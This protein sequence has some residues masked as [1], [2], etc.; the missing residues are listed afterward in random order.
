[1]P[2][3]TSKPINKNTMKTLS[4]IKSLYFWLNEIESEKNYSFTFYIG[5][6]CFDESNKK[7]IIREIISRN[8]SK[9]NFTE[10]ELGNFALDSECSNISGIIWHSQE[11]VPEC[12]VYDEINE[13]YIHEDDA[14]YGYIRRYEGYFRDN[15]K[16]YQHNGMY[17]HENSLGYHHLEV[18]GDGDILESKYAVYCE[19]VDEYYHIDY[20][21][22][23]ELTGCH[24]RH[25]ENLPKLDSDS[26]ICGY[27]DSPE[28]KDLSNG[29]KF[30]IGFEI[31]KLNFFGNDSE[32]DKIGEYNIFKGFEL[33]SSCGVEA[34]TNILPLHSCPENDVFNW[35]NEAKDVINS[36]YDRNCGGHINLSCSNLSGSDFYDKLKPYLSAW[37][38][39]YRFRLKNTYCS[40]NKDLKDKNAGKYS[41]VNLKGKIVEIRIPN[42]VPNVE[43]LKLRYKLAYHTCIAAENEIPFEQFKDN[44]TAIIKAMYEN[45]FKAK[46]ILNLADKFKEYIVNDIISDEIEEYV[47]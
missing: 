23:S 34:I 6:Y 8:L 45:K 28:A 12:I 38:A 9:C 19:D 7:E 4:E 1:V 35:M 40:G 14:I 10:T 20:C 15:E 39:L 16:Y 32:G 22:Y 3:K 31:E 13:N 33:D 21:Y 18:D 41:T 37:Y 25:L 27:H 5:N 47:K 11:E 43:T 30:K 44:I 24:Y 2:T 46:K 26:V 36:E 42:A 29:S 17:Y